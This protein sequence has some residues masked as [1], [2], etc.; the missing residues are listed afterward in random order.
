MPGARRRPV[1]RPC[2][3]ARP[4]SPPTASPGSPRRASSWSRGEHLDAD[5]I[6]TATGLNLLP[7][8]GMS[9]IDRRRA[10]RRLEDR[11]LQGDDDLRRPE[12]HD[13]D[14]LHERLVDAQGRPGQPRT[15]AGCST[16][17]TPTATSSATP[18]APARGRRRCRSS[19]SRRATCSAASTSCPSRARRT[20]WRLHQNYIR[21]VQLMRRGPLEDEGMTFQRPAPRRAERAVG[22]MDAYRVR[23]AAPPSS[24]ARPA[25]SA[26]RW[27]PP[28]AARGSNLVLLD[29][30]AER[31]DGV[32]DGRARAPIRQ[33][34]VDHLRRRPL[35]RRAPPTQVG[36]CSSRP[37]TR[38][39]RCWS[40]TP[41]SRSAAAST[42]SPSR[43]ST[44]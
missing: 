43:S 7:M 8:G 12:L 3:R 22:L 5:V 21:D 27:P 29:R 42:R 41:A 34:A 23:A 36:R 24:P 30:D 33:L 39:P 16:T 31:L 4:R 35:R 26:R 20:P 32:A 11:L 40:T 17:S 14:R 25:A 18:V 1:P 9:L 38:R 28:L 10:G 2:A 44:G 13:G 15:S 6:V 37:S 19:T